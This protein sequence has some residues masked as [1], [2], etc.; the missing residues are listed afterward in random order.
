[1][2]F[3]YLIFDAVILG[4]SVI[5]LAFYKNAKWP[6][7]RRALKAILIMGLLY[8]I[9]DY[10]VTG[11]WWTFNPA[12][13][14]GY[15][16]GKL[17]IEEILFFVCVPWSCLVIWEN[18]KPKVNGKKVNF[19]YKTIITAGLLLSSAFLL[20]GYFYASIVFLVLSSV[21]FLDFRTVKWLTLK[22][23]KLFVVI[24][25]VLIFLFN[26]YLTA[27]PVVIYSPLAITGFRI[28]TIPFEDFI[29]GI[30]LIIGLI[31]LYEKR[32]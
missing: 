8:V 27:R 1:M 5:G 30:A 28:V 31:A 13:I 12:F 26:G 9:W 15:W 22:S 11:F 6:S 20:M 2:K 3:E 16:I 21:L 7:V 25:T 18:L 23:S 4:S 10:I 24:T 19:F 29:Y 14:T 32:G 17:P